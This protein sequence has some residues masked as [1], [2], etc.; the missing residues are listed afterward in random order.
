MSEHEEPQISELIGKLSHL[1][2]E[3]L[4]PKGT[5]LLRQGMKLDSFFVIKEGL[6]KAFYVT[7]DG[8]E[9][10]KSI[11][12]EGECIASA[13]VI[14]TGDVCPF[15]LV[16][17]EDTHLIEIPGRTLLKLV[18]DDPG[19][20][21]SINKMLLQIAM[22]KERREYELLC[23]SAE[24]RYRSFCQ[25][26]PHL[27]ERMSQLDIARYLGITPV[28]LSRIRKRIRAEAQP[29]LDIGY[30][31]DSTMDNGNETKPG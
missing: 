1:G 24:Q 17:L 28:A 19:L 16:A 6:A 7:V 13:Q 15:Y 10:I 5:V 3:R 27:A 9:F 11:I 4:A 18:G 14:V 12:S 29:V 21:Q 26:N 2:T 20:A 22:K 30:I 31:R 23:L 25:R 8:R